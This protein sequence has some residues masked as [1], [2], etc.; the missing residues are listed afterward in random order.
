M[1]VYLLHFDVPLSG[2]ARHYMGSS[3]PGGLWPRLKDH[4]DGY[5][6]NIMRHVGARGITWQLAR[7]WPGYRAAERH[8]K[9]RPIGSRGLKDKCPVCHSM[10]RVNRWAGGGRAIS[11]RIR[12]Y[13]IDRT[14]THYDRAA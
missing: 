13:V 4:A 7:T 6:A 9:G 10:P 5:G 11:K 8:L 12:Q 2:H 3:H 14:A 1:P